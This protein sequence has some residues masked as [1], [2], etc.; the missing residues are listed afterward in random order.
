MPGD[1]CP[2]CGSFTGEHGFSF[3]WDR[4][5][6]EADEARSR[7]LQDASSD[8]HGIPVPSVMQKIIDLHAPEDIM[9]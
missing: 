3:D 5:K 2:Y 8:D 1:R 7:V 6:K 9:D 4:K